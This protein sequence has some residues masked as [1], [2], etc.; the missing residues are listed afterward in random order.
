MFNWNHRCTCLSGNVLFGCRSIGRALAW[1]GRRH[2]TSSIRDSK[3]AC[4]GPDPVHSEGLSRSSTTLRIGTL[5]PIGSQAAACLM[6]LRCRKYRKP[7]SHWVDWDCKLP[8][9]FI[10]VQKTEHPM[11]KNFW[12]IVIGVIFLG[13]CAAMRDLLLPGNSE[14]DKSRRFYDQRSDNPYR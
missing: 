9:P 4:D 12:F 1:L 10:I 2:C 5:V 6:R 8:N 3:H 13:G 11:R 14:L 7:Q